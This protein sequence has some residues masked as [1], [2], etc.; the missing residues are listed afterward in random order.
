MKKILAILLSIALI[1]SLSAVIASAAGVDDADYR[2][3]TGWTKVTGG[4][5]DPEDGVY[6]DVPFDAV[7]T[8]AI[9]FM[10]LDGVGGW[11]S[12]AEIVF[13]FTD[14]AAPE[15]KAGAQTFDYSEGFAEYAIDGDPDT[16]WHSL[17]NE[18]AYYDNNPD[19]EFFSAGDDYPQVLIIEFDRAATLDKMSYLAR[20][21]ASN[22]TVYEYEIWAANYTPPAAPE[23]EP[24]AEVA[25]GIGGGAEN[26]HV[27]A[28]APAPVVAAPVA[29]P[30]TGYG[31]TGIVLAFVAFAATAL[32]TTK[33][34][35]RRR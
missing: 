26:V 34:I 30:Q 28:P 27:P 7:T 1:T 19:G 18:G 9:K 25:D 23:P 17:W 14:G 24:V 21:S 33:A 6:V 22:G 4:A 20:P 5:M 35:K 11:A 13:N 16:F 32:V 3:N 29:V 15:M 31:Y 12:A 2:D 8:T 10:V